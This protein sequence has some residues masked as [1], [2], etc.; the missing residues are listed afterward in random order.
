MEWTLF[1][2]VMILMT[3][4]TICL[5]SLKLRKGDKGEIGEAGQ[6]GGLRLK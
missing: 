1:W 3:W 4:S 5:N 2:Q 6:P